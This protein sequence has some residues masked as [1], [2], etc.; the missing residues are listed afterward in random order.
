M[1]NVPENKN[2]LKDVKA[3]PA[4]FFANV[5]AIAGWV[6]EITIEARIY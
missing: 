3:L 2:T 5:K 1:K 4:K 6:N